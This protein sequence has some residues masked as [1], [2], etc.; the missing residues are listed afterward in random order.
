M[1][2][3]FRL[4]YRNE[5]VVTVLAVLCLLFLILGAPGIALYSGLVLVVASLVVHGW[6]LRH[7]ARQLARVVAELAATPGAGATIPASTRVVHVALPPTRVPAQVRTTAHTG[8][9]ARGE[10]ATR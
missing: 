6:L 3:S 9:P 1:N 4:D 8:H 7:Q 5:L 2:R 10:T